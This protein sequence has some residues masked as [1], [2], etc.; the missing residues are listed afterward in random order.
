[1]KSLVFITQ[2]SRLKRSTNK[3]LS[4]GWQFSQQRRWKRRITDQIDSAVALLDHCGAALDPVSAII[5][6]D[7]GELMDCCAVNVSAED[8]VDL[9]LLGVADYRF[10]EFA[11]K[12]NS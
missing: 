11:D 9:E 5:I 10:L 4:Y 7:A 3:I 1:M 2:E 12:T 8:C 6:S